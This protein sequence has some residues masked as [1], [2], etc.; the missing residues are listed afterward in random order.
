MASSGSQRRAMP[1]AGPRKIHATILNSYA[2]PSLFGFR[3][4][5]PPAPIIYKFMT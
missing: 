2:V 4:K 1:E 3:N 5:K